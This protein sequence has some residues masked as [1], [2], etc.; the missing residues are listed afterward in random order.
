MNKRLRGFIGC[1]TEH[2]GH[3]AYLQAAL[4][5]WCQPETWGHGLFGPSKTFI[6][7]LEKG[8]PNFDFSVFLI[9][10]QDVSIIRGKKRQVPRDNLIFEIGLCYGALGRERTFLIY[11]DGQRPHLPTD[12]AA[13]TLLPYDGGAAN[14]RAAFE[15][16]SNRIKDEL[17]GLGPK[18]CRACKPLLS[19][20]SAA[21]TREVDFINEHFQKICFSKGA[22]RTSWSAH[23]QY[24]LSRAS[25]GII[26][27][28]MRFS[29]ECVNITDAPIQYETLLIAPDDEAT[30][31]LEELT[32]E[33]ILG[34]RKSLL[35][36]SEINLRDGISKTRSRTGR[37]QT[38]SFIMEK[39]HR[40]RVCLKY[41][42]RYPVCTRKQQL[43][44]TLAV[45]DPTLSATIYVE[46]PNGYDFILMAPHQLKADVW[47][48]SWEFRIPSPLLPY[49]LLEYTFRKK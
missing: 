10:P 14:M 17:F 7:S 46:V 23:L 11:P 44:N 25:K 20:G 31:Y 4:A 38:K 27:E 40:Y 19:R 45:L 33:D 26:V 37:K 9:S 12:L 35:M 32:S 22:I 49:H 6:E 1:A 18:E 43:R 13:V 42:N 28:N 21:F 29:F 3:A 36:Q 2:N 34:N 39:Q 16:P 41:V 8:I 24:D 48:K 47:K 15:I 5:T 30:G